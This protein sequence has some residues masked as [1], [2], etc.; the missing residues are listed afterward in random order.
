MTSYY[1]DKLIWEIFDSQLNLILLI[2]FSCEL[3]QIMTRYDLLQHDLI[4]ILVNFSIGANRW[5]FWE[6]SPKW[7]Y[8]FIEQVLYCSEL[9]RKM[10]FAI[11][12]ANFV[13]IQSS[14]IRWYRFVFERMQSRLVY[15]F[16]L[17]KWHNTICCLSCRCRLY[18]GLMT[19]PTR[20]S[21][22]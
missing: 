6:K 14:R 18:R 5:I 10:V 19:C 12:K 13:D 1:I 2:N 11:Q 15:A 3:G 9:G 22:T 21:W 7:G 17:Y 8:K 20:S 16:I 4:L